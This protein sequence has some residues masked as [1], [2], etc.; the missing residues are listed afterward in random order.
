VD[1]GRLVSV[2]VPVFNVEDYITECLMSLWNQDYHNLEIIIIDDAS[3]DKTIEIA[4]PVIEKL[5]QKYPVQF[6]RQPENQGVSAARNL[7]IMQSAGE[8]LFFV[9]SDDTLPAGALSSL[10]AVLSEQGQ[11]NPPGGIDFITG[12]YIRRDNKPVQ[13]NEILHFNNDNHKAVLKAYMENKYNMHVWGK[14]ISKEFLIQ[15]NI[16]FEPRRRLEDVLFGFKMAYHAKSI[17]TCREITYE[18]RI[19]DKN[20]LTTT[21]G[22]DMCEGG[23]NNIAKEIEIFNCSELYVQFYEHIIAYSYYILTEAYINNI[24]ETIKLIKAIKSLLA[25]V[26]KGRGTS[27]KVKIKA[28]LLALPPGILNFVMLPYGLRTPSH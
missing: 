19:R 15:N 18:Y 23:V 2:I 24:T 7:G 11:I 16:F 9:D 28:I 1:S 27:L 4:C 3:T 5:K 13:K 25:K 14:L 6:Y 26:K 21:Y 22:F 12:N 10:V 8:Y 20:S 17:A